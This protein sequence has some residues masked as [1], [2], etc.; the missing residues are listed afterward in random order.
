MAYIFGKIKC[1]FCDTKD[2]LMHSVCAYGIYGEA[3]KRLFYHPECLEMVEYKP[4]KFGH[5]MMDKAI[6]VAELKQ[7][8]IK[9]Y[10][11]K[12][13]EEFE[14]KVQKLHRNHF[15]RMMPKK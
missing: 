1:Y 7:N 9:T 4:E 10:N 11:E 3:G 8:N 2:G 13:Y 14:K 15:E 6:H 5:I 12:I